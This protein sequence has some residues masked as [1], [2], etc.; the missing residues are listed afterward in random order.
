MSRLNIFTKIIGNVGDFKKYILQ[1]IKNILNRQLFSNINVNAEAIKDIVISNIIS[2]PEYSSLISG[3]LRNQFGLPTSQLVDGII[4]EL[5]DISI[6]IQK[7]KISG[8]KIDANIAISLI[9][10]DFQQI[11]SSNYASFTTEKGSQLNWLRWLLLEGNNSVI[12]GYR[13]AP[14]ASP[15]SRTGKGIMVSGNSAVYRVPPEFAGT[16]EDNWI[17]RG[18]DASLPQIESY[19]NQ[20]IQ[21]S[22]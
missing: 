21:K 18:I 8:N 19:I 6:D 12:I 5:K 11:L 17:T 9:K 14:I 22:L 1:N 13:Y 15:Y 16:A 7:P 20:L 4:E 2:Q 3:S 10:E